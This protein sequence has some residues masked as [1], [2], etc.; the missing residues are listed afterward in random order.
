MPSMTYAMSTHCP[1]DDCELIPCGR[2]C[3]VSRYWETYGKVLYKPVRVGQKRGELAD[4]VP[5]GDIVI[6]KHRWK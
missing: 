5:D 2:T 3:K 6:T 4:R 1:C